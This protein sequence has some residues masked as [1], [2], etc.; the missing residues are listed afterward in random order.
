MEQPRYIRSSINVGSDHVMILDA[1]DLNLAR[2]HHT[3]ATNRST[4]FTLLRPYVVRHHNLSNEVQTTT[5]NT[6]T[7]ERHSYRYLSKI[8][9]EEGM[10][11]EEMMCSICLVELL[12]GTQAT[13]LWCSHL[14]HEGCIM[15][16]L[17]RS[18]TC[19]LC[20]QIVQNM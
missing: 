18:N 11:S 20:R 8:R 19:P 4:R 2:P 12:V 9:V 16:W 17:C 15:K 10:E 3:H 13:R 7:I 5:R 1:V 14:Y 6:E